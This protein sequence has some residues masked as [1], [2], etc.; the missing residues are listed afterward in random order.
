[1][2]YT[3][4]ILLSIF[5]VL[6]SCEQKIDYAGVFEIEALDNDTVRICNSRS[7][8]KKSAGEYHLSGVVKIPAAIYG[9]KVVEI[10]K[11]A[12]YGC[13]DVKEFIIPNT[14]KIIDEEAFKGCTSLRKIFIPKS[15]TKIASNTF[16]ECSS[17][18]TID[19]EDTAAWRGYR[20]YLS[21]VRYITI[22]ASEPE[23]P[24][25]ADEENSNMKDT[26]YRVNGVSFTMKPI[27]V[28][29]DAILGDDNWK[30]LN[31]WYTNKE[32]RVNLSAYYIGETEVTQEL[33]Q[34]VMGA[35][36]SWFK[37]SG[38]NPVETVSWYDCV[39]FCN[40]LTAKVMGENHC[41]YK[42]NGVNVTADFSQKGFRLP[43]EA[44][45]EYAAM[46]G[47]K[48]KYAGCN[49]ENELKGYAWYKDN[50]D[51]KTHEVKTK[52]PNGY[53]LYDMSGNV[54]EWCW[55]WW[56]ATTPSG[57]NDPHSAD[58]G[59]YRVWRGGSWAFNASHC[60]RTYRAFIE[61]DNSGVNLGLRL[62]LRP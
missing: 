37:D 6:T 9:K 60:E 11:K 50:S 51:N 26:I 16:Y 21:D 15:V 41:V 61:P 5:T 30:D 27:A 58:A 31:G 29:K 25:D 39:K 56:S 23:P 20:F 24:S 45:W 62:A 13:S 53:G 3:L 35:N 14:V 7:G 44:E 19:V 55:D 48:H 32:H 12:F 36:P 8:Y 42:I 22:D 18:Q 17:L 57:G 34:S 2:K 54:W 28:V 40:E 59:V 46:G 52:E 1:M 10:G 49:S 4:V 33:W 43:T 38:K 47:K